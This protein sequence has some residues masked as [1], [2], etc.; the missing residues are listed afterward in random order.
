M[1][2]DQ[3]SVV[4]DASDPVEA[5]VTQDDAQQIFAVVADPSDQSTAV[6]EANQFSADPISVGDPSAPV[7]ANVSEPGPPGLSAYELWLLQPGNAGKT[8]DAFLLSLVGP[9]GAPGLNGLDGAKGADGLN[10]AP[11]LDGAPGAPGIPGAPGAPG[12]TRPKSPVFTYTAGLLTQVSYADGT[13]K[14]ISYASGRV[15]QID[16]TKGAVTTRK[17]MTYSGDVLMR[18]DEVTL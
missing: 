17:T 8:V 4:V 16:T 13:I 6:V 2:C 18:I 10:G 11:G 3:I 15:S 7:E 14:T 5:V 1:A 12:E 9:A